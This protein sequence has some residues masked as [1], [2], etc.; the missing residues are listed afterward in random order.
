MCRQKPHRQSTS[1]VPTSSPRVLLIPAPDASDSSTPSQPPSC[2]ED[3][4]TI[5]PPSRPSSTPDRDRLPCGTG[6]TAEILVEVLRHTL[7]FVRAT[8][9]G[10]SVC[11]KDACSPSGSKQARGGVD[12]EGVSEYGATESK[13]ICRPAGVQRSA[14][15]LSRHKHGKE[16]LPRVSRMGTTSQ[17][18][19][20][21]LT[22][23][24]CLRTTFSSQERV[25]FRQN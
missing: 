7:C 4:N 5:P 11:R 21:R 25:R 17:E 23:S 6:L 20:I 15:H 18:N 12:Q 14:G 2:S 22:L 9:S 24:C 13:Q 10:K 16:S 8:C 19:M 1:A 3:G